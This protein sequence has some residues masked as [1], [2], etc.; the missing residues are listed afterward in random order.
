MTTLSNDDFRKLINNTAPAQ[1]IPQ[2]TP[3]IVPI[4]SESRTPKFQTKES[5]SKP[6]EPSK[7]RDRAEERRRGIDVQAED[8]YMDEDSKIESPTDQIDEEDEEDEELEKAFTHKAEKIK[9][10]PIV[11][12]RKVTTFKTHVGRNIFRFLQE[13]ATEKSKI[14][15][16]RS[17]NFLSNR[18]TF[19]Y[20][21]ETNDPKKESKPQ[22]S[23]PSGISMQ[24]KSL[25]PRNVTK[26]APKQEV[27]S[28]TPAKT[29]ESSN[30]SSQ[31]CLPRIKLQAVNK[32]QTPD[33]SEIRKQNS[34][35]SQDL[36]QRISNIVNELQRDKI[37]GD[38]E[39]Y[40]KRKRKQIKKQ[41]KLEELQQKEETERKKE[42]KAKILEDDVD[43]IFGDTDDDYVCAVVPKPQEKKEPK[44]KPI[45]QE[46]E[47]EPIRP[48]L[49]SSE[50]EQLLRK[51]VEEAR[52]QKKRIEQDRKHQTFSKKDYETGYAA[53]FQNPN[54]KSAEQG[55]KKK[56]KRQED[57]VYIKGYEDAK[58]EYDEVEYDSAEEQ[59]EK[60]HSASLE[61]VFKERADETR[62][63]KRGRGRGGG[64][65][66]G[67]DKGK[68]QK[69]QKDWQQMQVVLKR[70][71][72][73]D[74]VEGL[75][76]EEDDEP[77]KKKKKRQES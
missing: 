70:K 39:I 73:D 56:K 42:E 17:D 19:I 49:F 24:L 20:S 65:T 44:S 68:K 31:F 6:T 54:I 16:S 76:E 22:E 47:P 75:H 10:V 35:I 74:Y 71:Y 63:S 72:G 29:P 64:A 48:A 45:E 61:A 32:R 53:I 38:F 69:T 55:E 12:E 30:T 18:M 46:A 67:R 37:N 51:Q 58:M 23:R 40:S 33:Q 3:A 2:N 14:A 62:T 57:D 4:K 9:E 77:S 25:K 41:R 7:Y 43:N 52:E 21:L 8:L 26:Q 15:E 5:R 60:M 11:E 50:A 1:R 34:T 36:L 27:K 28:T 66:K 13:S 59:D